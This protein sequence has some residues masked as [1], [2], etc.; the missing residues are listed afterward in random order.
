MPSNNSLVPD[1]DWLAASCEPDESWSGPGPMLVNLQAWMERLAAAGLHHL[2]SATY[3]AA[4]TARAHWDAW[5]NESPE[6][7]QES[8]LDGQPPTEQLAAVARWLASPSDDQ[9]ALALETVDLTKQLHWFHEEY[10]DVWFDEPGMWAVESSEFCVLSLTRD[11]YSHI[12]RATLAAISVSCATNSFRRSP[13][14]DI[15]PALTTIVT[16]IGDR[17]AGN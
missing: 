1:L 15:R 7:A 12:S 8:I 2:V 3:A 16:A 6:S 10:C 9:M 14:E 13:E 5:Y 11:P 17:L 4:S